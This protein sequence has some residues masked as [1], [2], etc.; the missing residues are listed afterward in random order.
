MMH[1]GDYG[2]MGMHFGWWAFVIALVIVSIGLFYR[3][4]HRR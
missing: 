1:N 3:S 2:Y 4:R